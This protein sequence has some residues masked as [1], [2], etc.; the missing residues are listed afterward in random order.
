MFFKEC[1]LAGR[2]YYDADEVWEELRI[3]TLLELRREEDNRYDPNAIE[4]IYHRKNDKNDND[5][6]FKLG[7][8]PRSENIEMAAIMDMGWGKMFECRI[9][10]ICPDENYEN[11][12]GMTIRIKR[13]PNRQI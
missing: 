6:C 13:N 11:Q 7:F 1:H 4:V 10:R 2:T 8:I 5:D 9:S 12:I 3:G